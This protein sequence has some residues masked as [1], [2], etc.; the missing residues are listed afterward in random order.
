[1]GQYYSD[2]TRESDLHALPDIET[3]KG[4]DYGGDFLEGPSE[5]GDKWRCWY[6]GDFYDDY[7]DAWECC[8][9]EPDKW[10]YWYCMPGCLPD[11]EP[12]GPFD[13]EELALAHARGSHE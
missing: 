7:G 10:Y 1:M 13:T 6:C 9:P 5:H 8:G 2:I 11:S 4:D 3:F 12:W